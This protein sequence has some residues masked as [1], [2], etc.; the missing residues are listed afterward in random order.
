VEKKI[1]R[2][3]SRPPHGV[4]ISEERRMIQSFR[5]LRVFQKSY[6]LAMD[7]FE[8]TKRFPAEERFALTDQLRRSSRSISANIAEGWG[9]RRFENVFK[10]HL[11]D[12]VGS[13]KETRFWLECARDCGYLTEEV[14]N[15]LNERC[16]EVDKMLHVLHRNWRS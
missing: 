1:P 15:S 5:D 8:Q 10:K 7:I 6:A 12:A 16:D 4:I 3:E 14:C 11:I 9:K 13:T 2:L